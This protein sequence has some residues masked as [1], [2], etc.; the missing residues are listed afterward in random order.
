VRPGELQHRLTSAASA[1][2]CV[3]A[4]AA[5]RIDGRR[6]VAT[7]GLTAVGTISPVEVGTP[8]RIGSI[9]KVC[10]ATV[11][12]RALQDAGRSLDDPVEDLMPGRVPDEASSATW[13]HILTH[14]SGIDGTFWEG[15]GD[16]Q[17]AIGLYT[18]QIPTL[19]VAFEPGDSWGYSNSGYV[20]AGAAIETLT[21]EA[22]DL[23]TT[24]HLRTLA[25]LETLTLWTDTP[26]PGA[27]YGHHLAGDGPRPAPLPSGL[28]A[29]APTGSAGF[30]TPTDL[31]NLA[32]GLLHDSWEDL[33]SDARMMPPG[34]GTS[35]THQ[36][37]GWRIYR[38]DNTVMFGHDGGAAGMGSFLRWIPTTESGIAVM[39]NTNPSAMFVWAD[40][41]QWFFDQTGVT[42]PD[43]LEAEHG[44]AVEREWVGEYRARDAT[45]VVGAGEQ[46]LTLE[47]DG[48]G[49][50]LRRSVTL[51]PLG[52]G[53]YRSDQ[54]I[55][56]P[57]R[58]ISFE[59]P[60]SRYRLLHA[61]PFTARA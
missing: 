42:V 46:T 25:D 14:A 53:V 17:D 33:V 7:T 57:T 27:A 52:P 40:L 36:G 5:M 29:L 21:G 10:T 31:L 55:A 39:G 49:G 12:T 4:S 60:R 45:F 34:G 54:M 47:A 3:G 18:E 44:A 19:P 59:R 50:A 37:R 15:F 38:W 43:W 26:P 58:I 23:A 35:A 30:C 56:D 2:G 22:W 16:R 61:G 20:L 48:L 24:D 1:S 41:S 11:L 51:T 6:I 32:E 8:F 28:R 13:R 9:A